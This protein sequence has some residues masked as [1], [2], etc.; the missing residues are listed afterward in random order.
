MNFEHQVKA[1]IEQGKIKKQEAHKDQIEALIKR[2]RKDIEVSKLN[3]EIDYDTA[4]GTAYNSMLKA[5][6]AFMLSKGYRTDDGAQH[7]TTVDFC[8]FFMDGET[9]KLAKTFDRMRRI[10][11]II[12]YDPFDYAGFEKEDVISAIESAQKFLKTIE[13]LLGLS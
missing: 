3:L 9:N 4:F 13:K 6:R 10:R 11:N 8:S 7:K 5:G 12:A 1:W 2:A